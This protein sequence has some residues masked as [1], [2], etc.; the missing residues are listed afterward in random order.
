M[1]APLSSQLSGALVDREV[2]QGTARPAL[3]G[4]NAITQTQAAAIAWLGADRARSIFQAAGLE[5]RF[6]DPPGE[7]VPETEVAGLVAALFGALP[8][9][10]ALSGIDDSGALTADYLL[11]NR[12]PRFA[13][14]I[15]K[16]LPPAAAARMLARA[17]ARHAW[18]FA[19][20][21][22]FSVTVGRGVTFRIARNPMCRDLRHQHCLCRFHARVFTV[23]FQTLVHPDA[24]AVETACCGQGAKACI[25]E[26][27]W[28]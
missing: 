4:P 28:T 24:H 8:H 10:L 18:T 22:E 1:N 2:A 16:W 13:Q 9:E 17:I 25:F 14:V 15:L 20:S 7:M 5:Q 6:D 19:G 12:I 27:R 3:I 26:V 23:L 21:G 11:E